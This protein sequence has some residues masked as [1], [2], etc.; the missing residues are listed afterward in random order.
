MRVL[1]CSFLNMVLVGME[2]IC[3]YSSHV[4]TYNGVTESDNHNRHLCFKR[5]EMAGTEQL[6]IH[7][8]FK[9]LMRT[10]GQ[11]D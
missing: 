4:K 3:F 6:S 1:E 5:E 10:S 2:N 7:N 11:F 9:A 8:N